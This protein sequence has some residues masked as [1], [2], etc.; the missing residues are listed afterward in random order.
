MAQRSSVHARHFLLLFKASF[1]ACVAG[2]TVSGRTGHSS[3]GG[4]ALEIAHVLRTQAS[5]WNTGDI[6]TFMSAY[7]RSPQLTFVSGGN[8]TRGWEP[9]LEG[10]RQR[11][12]TR[13]AMGRLTFDQIEVRE[14][15]RDAALVLG[16]WR[17]DRELPEQPVGG[18]FTLLFRRLEGKWVI[19]YD[20]TSKD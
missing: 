1:A 17:L 5:A 6:E 9:T 13:A 4:V 2:C 3:A 16:R 19:V 12:P 8:V 18:R 10:Y 7:W 20:H 15:A 11:Y 14:L